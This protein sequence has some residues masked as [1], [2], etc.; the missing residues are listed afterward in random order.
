[1]ARWE[2][3]ARKRL[4]DAALELFAEQGYERTTVID[5]SE[6]A[7]LTKSTFFRHYLDK[8]EVL[9]DGDEMYSL[10]GEAIVAAPVGVPPL[11]AVGAALNSV[12]AVVFTPERREFVAHRRAVIAAS[13]ELQE[14]E[15]LKALA[16]A[17]AMVDALTRRGAPDLIARVAAELGTLALAVTYERWTAPGND[18]SFN[19]LARR[20]LDE[21]KAAT[22]SC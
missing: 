1:M 5:I 22:A 12:G 21:L 13:P 7:G 14:R 16:L 4:A 8:R 9:F 15:A 6:R 20:T 18:E 11:Q 2:G 17:T 10:L 19:T 3:N